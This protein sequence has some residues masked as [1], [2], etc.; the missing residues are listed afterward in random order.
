MNLGANPPGPS[1][2]IVIPAPDGWDHTFR[3]LVSLAA[4]SNGHRPETLVVD[5]GTTDETRLALPH[6]EGVQQL[7]NEAP[8]GFARA[9]NQG[10]A[11]VQGDVVVLLDR[12]VE[13]APG[14]L[15]PI[16]RAFADPQVAAAVPS[17]R[18]GAAGA[19]V[20]VRAETFRSMGGLDEARGDAVE[21]LLGRLLEEGRRVELIEEASVVRPE[22]APQA[23]P[24]APAAQEPAVAP[25]Q[26]PPRELLETLEKIHQ[27]R[28]TL[29][30]T[31]RQL[32]SKYPAD[33]DARYLLAEATHA[34]QQDDVAAQLYQELARDCPPNER[35]RVEQA[36]QA[37]QT[38]RG[39]FPQVLVERFSTSEYREGPNAEKW[40]NYAWNEIRRGREIVRTI[41]RL[42]PLRGKRVLDVGS[43]YGGMLISM[44]EQ[45][46]EAMGVE[47]DPER[48]RTAKT[49]FDQLGLSIPIHEADIC[50]DGTLDLL[51][52]AFDVVVC[53]D[54]LEHVLEPA[55]V[56][57]ALCGLL[58][59]GGV[60]Y[61]QVPNKYGA[62]QLM[63]DHHYGLV[64]LTALARAQS[65][66]YWCLDT[67]LPPGEYGVGYERTEPWY[68][69]VFA[70]GGVRLAQVEPYD[71]LD[72]LLWYSNAFS[73]MVDRL[74]Q[75]IHP[76]LP[77][78][79][80]ARIRRRMAA[81]ILHYHRS[82]QRVMA[83]PEG[84]ERAAFCDAAVRRVCVGLWRF[85]GVKEA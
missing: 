84:P 55:K 44:A 43:G 38:D 19:Y 51:G 40:S 48:A 13:V 37:C 62:D 29:R 73:A 23:A 12:D 46:A 18:S 52:G 41:R 54:V 80:A 81:V 47:I 33:R 76:A 78:R 8:T 66:E 64:G 50:Q 1:L 82:L 72:H 26:V 59:P 77:P 22:S 67:G 61:V 63:S 79:L 60:V 45:G 14:W 39:Y 4:H 21:A 49:R 83:M 11:S 85:V 5:D 71:S 6:L 10:A 24:A 57:S 25:G 36:L 69:R 9:C 74:K 58:R 2:S 3:C 53:Q 32:W 68:Q 28:A 70:R 27:L 65:I 34:A 20:A 35:R 15:D 7:R 75:P 30:E 56:I 31:A 42:T 17:G 16:Q